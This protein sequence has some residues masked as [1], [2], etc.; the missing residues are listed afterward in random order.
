MVRIL[1]LAML[2]AAGCALFSEGPPDNFCR[3]DT[4]CFRAQGEVCNL[5]TKTCV[6]GDGGVPVPD[7]AVDAGVDAVDAATE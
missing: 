7:S 5:D 4:D 2:A 6:P 1:V 3:G